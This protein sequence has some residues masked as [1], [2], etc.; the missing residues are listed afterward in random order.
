NTLANAVTAS[1]AG[2]VLFVNTGSVNYTAG[3]TLKANQ[4]LIGRG[5]ALAVDPDGAGALTP[6]SLLTAGTAPTLVTSAAS[7]AGVTLNTT[8]IRGLTIG[9]TTGAA[10]SGTSFGTLNVDNVAITNA[11]NNRTGDLLSLATGTVNATFSKLLTTSAGTAVS[12]NTV[13]GSL[14]VTNNA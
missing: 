5:V 14:T 13:G 7:T 6:I 9:S 10:I 3:I 2:D 8:T 4:Q 12:L 1:A 11:T